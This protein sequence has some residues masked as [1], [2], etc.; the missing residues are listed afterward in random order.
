MPLKCSFK[1]KFPRMYMF[2]GTWSPNLRFILKPKVEL[3]VF[4]RMRSEKITKNGENTLK[5]QFSG[6]V[7]ACIYVFRPEKSEYMV[8]FETGSRFNDVSAHAQ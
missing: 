6:P 1:A 5:M 7:S 8:Q 4:L 2:F 3:M